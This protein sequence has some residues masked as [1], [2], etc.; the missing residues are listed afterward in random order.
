MPSRDGTLPRAGA[1]YSSLSC[2]L[3][4]SQRS[5][6]YLIV[7]RTCSHP[8]VRTRQGFFFYL[9]DDVKFIALSVLACDALNKNI[10]IE[11]CCLHLCIC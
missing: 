5:Y 1:P 9:C 10:H 6:K 7:A 8:K 4:P 3:Q 11:L 2:S